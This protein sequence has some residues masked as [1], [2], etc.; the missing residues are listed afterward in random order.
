MGV[1]PLAFSVKFGR[2][3][4]CVWGGGGCSSQKANLILTSFISST[5]EQCS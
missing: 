4:E 1:N 2:V 5:A 3:C